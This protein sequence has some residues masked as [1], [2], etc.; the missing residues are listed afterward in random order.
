MERLGKIINLVSAV[1]IK[2]S[3]SLLII[4]ALFIVVDVMGRAFLGR[5]TI[6]CEEYSGYLLVALVFLAFAHTL[7]QGAHIRISVIISRFPSRIQDY[8]EA[9][10]STL[11]IVFVIYFAFQLWVMAKTYYY[12][13]VTSQSYI[14]MP[15]FIP[16]S[17]MLIGSIL[18][19]LQ[20]FIHILNVL[21]SLLMRRSN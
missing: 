18:L 13:M 20:F 8:L 11:A 17:L 14:P 19:I 12:G 4:M 15:L 1:G 10:V 21:R 6:I 3:S 9:F 7:S 16:S 5:S 2:V